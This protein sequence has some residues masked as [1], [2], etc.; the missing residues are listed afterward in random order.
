MEN[1]IV[2]TLDRISETLKNLDLSVRS[3][4]RLSEELIGL[5][6]SFKTLSNT[7]SQLDSNNI[8]TFFKAFDSVIAP[9]NSIAKLDS[10]LSGLGGLGDRLGDT[11]DDLS[12]FFKETEMGASIATS[13]TGLFSSALT[14]LASNPVVALIGGLGLLTGAALA[15][16]DAFGKQDENLQKLTEKSKELSEESISLRDAQ[17]QL[18]ESSN[19]S[20][21]SQLGKYEVIKSY[22]SEL[23]DLGKGNVEEIANAQGKV[24]E[25][26]SYCGET[27]VQ[28]ENGK[29]AWIG[30]TEEVLRNV[31]A[32]QLRAM[33]T[34]NEEAYGEALL[35]NGA[36]MSNMTESQQ[37][38]AEVQ[39]LFN[40]KVQEYID[41]G[42]S[43]SDA[44]AQASIWN[45]DLKTT[46]DECSEAYRNSSSAMV[47][48]Q[49]AL[50]KQSALEIQY[51]SLS[52]ES[53]I[54]IDELV[55]AYVTLTGKYDEQ[56]GKGNEVTATWGT[57]SQKLN[58]Y[59][60]VIAGHGDKFKQMTDKE[61]SNAQESRDV[62]IKMMAEK[63]VN[64]AQSYDEMVVSMG[65]AYNKMTDSER[66]S[67]KDQYN[68]MVSNCD[69]E[70]ALMLRQYAALSLY[71]DKH[72]IDINSKKGKQY[73]NSLKLAQDQGSA[74]GKK[75]LDSID[76][77]F[78]D[79]ERHPEL[80]ISNKTAMKSID[81]IQT[82]ISNL[83][84]TTVSV[85]F[86]STPNG[87]VVSGD[88]FSVKPY[89][90]GGFPET[91]QLFVAREAGPE[92]VGRIN[93]KTAV[94]NNDQIVTGISSG[95]YNAVRSAMQGNGGNGNMNI[96]ATFVMDGEVV[97]KQVIKYHNGVV[98]RTGTTPLMI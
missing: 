43:Y 32:M 6:E 2:L 64:S 10:T 67:L 35:N 15:L 49:F 65:N 50:D 91:G 23:I 68:A 60:E 88:K 96:H 24:D 85:K 89:M 74:E 28:I 7:T 16:N 98:K 72:N 53:K 94:A 77:E 87:F 81:D 27:V 75:Y 82:R 59:N 29:L 70:G 54:G 90:A 52:K 40:E 57:L 21:N 9:V 31:E 92:L 62:V 93:G 80:D 46:M 95:V 26:N 12:K 5:N 39:Q 11:K 61:K 79:K 36:I 76:D 13:A 30:N 17:K 20:M 55:G 14:F 8:F 19:D 56:L 97:G 18:N 47:E 48:N 41:K 58:D 3:I 1:E 86:K 42:M 73:I 22:A 83:K 71:L 66:A 84:G 51:M 38:L 4:T 34:A 45:S 44:Y 69:S 33:I 37:N 25:L 78:K 63:A